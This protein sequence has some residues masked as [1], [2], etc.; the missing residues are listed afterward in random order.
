[1]ADLQITAKYG[2][3]ISDKWPS[4]TSKIWG[5]NQG[6]KQG[7]GPYQSGISKMPLNGAAFYYVEQSGELTMNLNYSVEGL[8]GNYNLDHTDS[9]KTNKSGW[10]T[11][12][13]DHYDIEGFTYTNNVEDGSLFQE[14]S[15]L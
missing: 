14:K 2:A 15:H 8:N 10:T 3:N 5:T 9:F 11:T 6:R 7:E 1:M 12:A 13:E 4:S